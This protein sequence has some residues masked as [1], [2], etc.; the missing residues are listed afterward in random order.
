MLDTDNIRLPLTKAKFTNLRILE[1]VG[2][3][4]PLLLNYARSR[5]PNLQLIDDFSL[6]PGMPFVAS[7]AAHAVGYIRKDGIRYGCTSNKKTKADCYAFITEANVRSP[8][9]ISSLF[10]IQVAD[11]TP[12]VCAMVRRLM[13]DDNIPALPWDL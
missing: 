2:T 12:H 4:Y 1:P 11:K 3:A 8:V 7:R 9:E 13:S 10:V 5:W 6:E